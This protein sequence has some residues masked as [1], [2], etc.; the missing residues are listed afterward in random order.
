MIT[1]KELLTK[2]SLKHF[3][4]IKEI[5]RN[6]LM[7]MIDFERRPTKNISKKR[8]KSMLSFNV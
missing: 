1:T 7:R 2:P 3:R 5:F 4:Q 8:D 6:R